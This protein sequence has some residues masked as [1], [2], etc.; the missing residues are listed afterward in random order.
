MN[1]Y[2]KITALLLFIIPLVLVA[3]IWMWVGPVGF[4]QII[5]MI[6]TSIILYVTFFIGILMLIAIIVIIM[7]ERK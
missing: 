4:V 3:Y 2:E 6:I 7:L 1:I 5:I